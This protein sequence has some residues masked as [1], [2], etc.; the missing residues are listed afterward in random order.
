MRIL[1]IRCPCRPSHHRT[2]RETSK[3]LAPRRAPVPLRSAVHPRHQHGRPTAPTAVL[4]PGPGQQE[5]RR[6]QQ[7]DYGPVYGYA[8]VFAKIYAGGASVAGFLDEDLLY[9]FPSPQSSG[10]KAGGAKLTY[11]DARQGAV[12]L[13][14]ETHTR[15]GGRPAGQEA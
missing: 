2:R 1:E 9:V 5:L 14:A 8:D 13:G 11:S 12:P 10:I 15:W 7:V 4:R 3:L 6:A